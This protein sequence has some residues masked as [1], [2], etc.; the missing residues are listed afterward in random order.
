MTE[1]GIN[2]SRSKEVVEKLKAQDVVTVGSLL[3]L[4]E[5]KLEKNVGLRMG[6]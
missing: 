1:I 3:G 6:C 4:S 2:P 5:D